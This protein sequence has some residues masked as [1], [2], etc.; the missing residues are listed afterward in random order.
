V[1]IGMTFASPIKAAAS[2]RRLNDIVLYQAVIE[3]VPLMG[4]QTAR[5]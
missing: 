1:I 4:V 3:A 5:C 2:C